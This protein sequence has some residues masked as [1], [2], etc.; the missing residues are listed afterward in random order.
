MPRRPPSLAAGRRR[1]R[2]RRV[3]FLGAPQLKA[4]DDS[5]GAQRP[6]WRASTAVA[7]LRVPPPPLRARRHQR[8]A[9]AAQSLPQRADPPLPPCAAWRTRPLRLAGGPPHPRRHPPH[10]RAPALTFCPT[11]RT[12]GDAAAAVTG[13]L[14]RAGNCGHWPRAKP[15][16]PPLAR[17]EDPDATPTKP[18]APKALQRRPTAALLT[19]AS[20]HGRPPRAVPLPP[21][22]TV[23]TPRRDSRGPSSSQR[24][25]T[26]AHSRLTA[27]GLPSRPLARATRAPQPTAT[28][29]RPPAPITP[30]ARRL[31]DPERGTRQTSCADADAAFATR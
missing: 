5:C 20:R 27:D 10:R 14:G 12:A 8:G 28:R 13:S 9:V 24:S 18:A 6:E 31:L 21:N 3:R 16:L 4:I 2:K 7:L 17:F 11:T 26:A 15:P 29:T 23:S 25:A 30:A 22:R 1:G 19:T